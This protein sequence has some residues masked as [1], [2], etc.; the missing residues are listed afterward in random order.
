MLIILHTCAYL[1]YHI[2]YYLVLNCCNILFNYCKT[3]II[4]ETF[5]SQGH[6][7]RFIHET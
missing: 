1:G 3:L 7:P 2:N 4:R 6:Q 5:F